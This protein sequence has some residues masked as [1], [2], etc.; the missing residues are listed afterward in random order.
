MRI[1]VVGAGAIGSLFAGKLSANPENEVYPVGRRGGGSRVHLEAIRRNG[2]LVSGETDAL[3]TKLTT[4]VNP[5]E[6]GPVDL[7]ILATKTYS[8][9][10]AAEASKPLLSDDTVFLIL[11]N[12]L[13]QEEEVFKHVPREQALRGI[14][15]NGVLPIA[16]GK[17]MHAGRGET[18]VGALSAGQE[19]M[20]SRVKDVFERAGLPTRISP[21]IH[22]DVWLKTLV[23]AGINA[24]GALY[25]K[26]NG[27]ILEGEETARL[28]EAAVREGALVA[29]ALGVLLP[30]DPLAKTRAVASATYQNKNSM[31]VDLEAGRRTEVDAINGYIASEGRRLSIPTP[32]NDEL[33]QRVRGLEARSLKPSLNKRRLKS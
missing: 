11:Q 24:V 19:E 9:A 27:E 8:T 25:G 26:R 22:A 33:A 23:N 3:F 6:V 10:E 12:G 31:W 7:V 29:Q 16:P 2:L 21:D 13:G 5:A 1:A 18:V 20:L 17:I 15:M 32:V 14:T 4:S 30:E 28:C